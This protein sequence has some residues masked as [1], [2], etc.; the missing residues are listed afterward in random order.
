MFIIIYADEVHDGLVL[1]GCTINLILTS[2]ASPSCHWFHNL[3]ISNRPIYER[4]Q[5]LC[6]L[7]W[8]DV[9]ERRSFKVEVKENPKRG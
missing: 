5:V 2:M 7:S 8:S 3:N 4:I 9:K 1:I 6:A